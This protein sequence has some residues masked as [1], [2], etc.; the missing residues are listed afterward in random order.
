MLTVQ[1]L[2]SAGYYPF[3]YPLDF[4]H[5]KDTMK[6]NKID[7]QISFKLPMDIHEGLQELSIKSCEK[8]SPIIRRALE[9]YIKRNKHTQSIKLPYRETHLTLPISFMVAPSMYAE[10]NT[11]AYKTDRQIK[12]IT[13]LVIQALAEHIE[14]HKETIP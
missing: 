1:R 12:T 10:L 13:S 6:A 14:L 3:Y 5:T 9:E 11:M 4:I 8:M 7:R 2:T